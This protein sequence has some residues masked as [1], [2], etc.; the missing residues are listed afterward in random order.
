MVFSL[1]PGDSI[2]PAAVIEAST[3]GK[4]QQA[5]VNVVDQALAA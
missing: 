4:E 1:S 2:L 3:A 5:I